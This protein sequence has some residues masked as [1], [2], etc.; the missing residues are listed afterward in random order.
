MHLQEGYTV[1]E[2]AKD[3]A[4]FERLVAGGAEVP[5]ITDEVLASTCVL[6]LV[7]VYVVQV[8]S[9]HTVCRAPTCVCMHGRTRMVGALNLEGMRLHVGA[10]PTSTSSYLDT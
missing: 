7:L 6:Q 1:L 9:T 2:V 4:T 5:E 10:C 8:S 3:A